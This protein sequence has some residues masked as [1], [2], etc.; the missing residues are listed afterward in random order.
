MGRQLHSQSVAPFVSRKHLLDWFIPEAVL[1]RRL[2][3]MCFA[4]FPCAF[5]LP[6]TT[7]A[8][9]KQPLSRE[10]LAVLCAQAWKPS[11]RHGGEKR[12]AAGG[13]LQACI[14]K[15]LVSFHTGADPDMSP[16]AI[17]QSTG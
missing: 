10:P 4:G 6:S 17:A 7:G 5:V 12:T 2:R 16:G 1:R 3:W 9:G 8:Q 15:D 14:G 11:V 13:C